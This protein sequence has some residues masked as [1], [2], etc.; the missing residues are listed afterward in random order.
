MPALQRKA[1]ETGADALVVVNSTHQDIKNLLYRATPNET[2]TDLDNKNGYSAP[3]AYIQTAE[4][5]RRIGEAGHNGL[6][7]DAV[8]INYRSPNGKADGAA[9]NQIGANTN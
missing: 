8:A 4:H 6:Y 9:S 2:E 7:I 1:C 5:T 3:G